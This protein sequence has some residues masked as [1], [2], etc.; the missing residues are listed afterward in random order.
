MN[1]TEFSK[2]VVMLYT[3]GSDYTITFNLCDNDGGGT[4]TINDIHSFGEFMNDNVSQHRVKDDEYSVQI[5]EI[6]IKE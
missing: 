5:L 3:S 1:L 2:L 6:K 4:F